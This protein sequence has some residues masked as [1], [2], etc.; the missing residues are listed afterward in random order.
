MPEGRAPPLPPPQLPPATM[1][2][3]PVRNEQHNVLECV[4]TLLRQHGEPRVRVIDDGSTDGT[5]ALVERRA[6]GEPRLTLVSAGP[7]ADGLA[8]QGARPLG[9]IAGD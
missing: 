4:E 2:L 8:R 9:G 7:L 6:A 1:I 3:L 5:A